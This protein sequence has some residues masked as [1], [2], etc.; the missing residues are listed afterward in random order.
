MDLPL[1]LRVLWRFKWLVAVG[2]V[3]AVGLAVLSMF[4]VSSKSPYLSYRSAEQ[5]KATQTLLITPP[6]AP[7]LGAGYSENADPSRYSTLGTIY[8]QFVMSDEV[9]RLINRTWPLTK[10]DVIQAFPV[11]A[12]SYNSNSPP[13]PLISVEV[14]SFSSVRALQLAKHTVAS[15]RDYVELLQA[16]NAIPTD[17]RVAISVVRSYEPPLLIAGRSKTLPAVVFLTIM[18][19]ITGIC[20]VL[21]NLR[22]R[23]RAVAHDDAQP[24]RR[25]A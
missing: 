3:I 6:G 24:L 14:T 15:F 2:F 17:R 18:L 10:Y 7:W 22:P 4:K 21:E 1:Y 23:V 20:L 5:W 13:L 16:Q 9:R 12:Q 19:G 8:V 25:S 11:L